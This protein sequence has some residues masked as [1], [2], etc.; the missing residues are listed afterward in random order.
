MKGLAQMNAL[1][2]LQEIRAGKLELTQSDRELLESI[3]LHYM[4]VVDMITPLLMEVADFN[5]AVVR[6]LQHFEEP[7]DGND[8]PP[9]EGGAVRGLNGAD[10]Q[11][12][13]QGSL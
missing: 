7:L 6:V 8:N 5:K 1:R 9:I 3:E 4:T 2:L 11:G 10:N 13:G 12:T